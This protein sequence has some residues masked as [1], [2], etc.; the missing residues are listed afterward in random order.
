MSK[1]IKGFIFVLVLVGVLFFSW[2]YNNEK[3]PVEI[4]LD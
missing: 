3:K 4:W 2:Q 1:F